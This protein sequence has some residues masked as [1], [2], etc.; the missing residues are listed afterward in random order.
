VA[1]V[2]STSFITYLSEV[3][4]VL[5]YYILHAHLCCSLSNI[6]ETNVFW[7]LYCWS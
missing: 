6:C 3:L 4:D 7:L 5:T 1:G 2:L